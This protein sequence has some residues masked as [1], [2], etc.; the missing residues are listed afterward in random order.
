MSVLELR[1]QSPHVNWKVS[2][3]GSGLTSVYA[4]KFLLSITL[5]SIS[6]QELNHHLSGN[7]DL[8]A[9]NE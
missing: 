9:D 3:E 7:R 2:H 5:D 6:I 1:L 8:P 4:T